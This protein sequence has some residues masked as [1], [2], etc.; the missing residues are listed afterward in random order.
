MHLEYAAD[1]GTRHIRTVGKIEREIADAIEVQGVAEQRSGDGVET[2]VQLDDQGIAGRVSGQ[3][4]RIVRRAEARVEVGSGSVMDG[5]VRSREKAEALGFF[6]TQP[7]RMI[8]RAKVSH[9]TVNMRVFLIFIGLAI[10]GWLV[11]LGLGL[12]RSPVAVAVAP[13]VWQN[14]PPTLIV[15]DGAEIFKRAFW[16]Q[17][18]VGDEILHAERHEWSDAGGLLRWQWFLVVKASPGL[19]K[20]LRDDNAF[21]L[22]PAATMAAAAVAEAPSWFNYETDDVTTLMGPDS[23]LRLMFSKSGNR[24]YATAAGRGF[25]RGAPEPA[26]PVQGAPEPGLPP[27]TSPPNLKQ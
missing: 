5:A 9:S 11:W 22:A 2:A 6:L 25:A 10:L 23:G 1:A 18:A 4:H 8:S 3:V 20:Y 13:I 17:P 27:A 19:I 14:D 15:T 16:R 26:S 24:L 21:G 7:N 12:P